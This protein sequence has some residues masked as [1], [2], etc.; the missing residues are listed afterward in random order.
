[1]LPAELGE[2]RAV[3]DEVHARPYAELRTP[4]R[5]TYLALLVSP[6]EREAEYSHLR[7]LAPQAQTVPAAQATHLQLELPGCRLKWERHGEFSS[8][9]VFVR[10]GSPVPWSE[11]ALARLPARWV[12]AIPGRLVVAAQALLERAP[13]EPPSAEQLA[14]YFD[15]WVPVGAAVSDGAGY[16]FSDFRIREDGFVRFLALDRSFTPQQA[17]RVLNRLFEIEAY[18]VLA[19]LALPEARRV[20][21]RVVAIEHD[22]RALTEAI[23]SAERADEDLLIALTGL[24]GQVENALAATQHRFGAS[25]A[26]YSLVRDRIRELREQRQPGLQT[27]DE[28][29]QRRLAP[30]IATVETASRRLGELSER[31]AR[32]SHLLATR[33][34]IARERQ[35]QA[36]LASMDRRAKIQLRLQQAVE[37]LS[38][39]AITYYVVGLVYYAARALE[40]A[41]YGIQP[42]MTAGIAL[43]VVGLGTFAGLAWLRRKAVAARR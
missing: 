12:A 35:N 43:P 36:L 6:E 32:A 28:F 24:A 22:L 37:G 33:V 39:A 1:M 26:Y 16:A 40:S 5:A 29:M 10:G 2:R 14:A 13:L 17:G 42:E 7:E 23:A 25:R 31:V 18:R 15:P 20:L 11:P 8:Y 30:A 38:V 41:G 21:G 4:E 27:L 19:L 3:A 9:T 34:S